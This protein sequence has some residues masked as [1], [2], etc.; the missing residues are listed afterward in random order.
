LS[1][2]GE[3]GFLSTEINNLTE[4]CHTNYKEW[5][6]LHESINRY[7]WGLTS[8]L[9]FHSDNRQEYITFALF[10]R[11]LG[12]FEGSYILIERGMVSET[13]VLLRTL[14]ETLFSLRAIAKDKEEAERFYQEHDYLKYTA[15]KKMLQANSQ[16]IPLNGR[17]HSKRLAELENEVKTRKLKP[18]SV[19]DW[20]KK[21]ELHDFY[22]SA[23]SYFSWTV[24]S[25]IM[26]IGQLLNGESDDSVRKILLSPNFEEVCKYLMT[27]IECIVI[28]LGSI[29]ELFHLKENDRIGEYD[30]SYKELYKKFIN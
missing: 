23:Y 11:M 30:R 1:E 8:R 17:D 21:A 27:G 4:K 3:E 2:F 5:F 29:N 28:A 9:K 20:A 16:V 14:M 12:I 10:L 26:E 25:N 19:E 18:S 24:H 15:L 22:I 13:K 6:E 7:C